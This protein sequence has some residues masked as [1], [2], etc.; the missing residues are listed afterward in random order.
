MF[1]ETVL[2]ISGKVMSLLEE[3]VVLGCKAFNL[4]AKGCLFLTCLGDAPNYANGI[5]NYKSAALKVLE[6]VP[7][8][9]IKS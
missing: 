7:S 1:L 8:D 4:Y 6:L 5:V 9:G 2:K 3:L